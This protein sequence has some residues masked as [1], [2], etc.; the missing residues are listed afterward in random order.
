MRKFVLFLLI[1]LSPLVFSQTLTLKD[2]IQKR[3]ENNPNY[4]ALKLNQNASEHGVKASK[5]VKTDNWI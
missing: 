3:L 1:F 5:R 4:K 2:A